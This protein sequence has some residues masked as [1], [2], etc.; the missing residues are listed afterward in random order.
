MTFFSKT[1]Y[2]HISSIL[3]PLSRDTHYY[4]VLSAFPFYTMLIH[5]RASVF[6]IASPTTYP[7][8]L[9]LDYFE[10]YRFEPTQV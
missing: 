4:V 10:G 2:L 3:Y 9:G 6:S 8:A 1:F 5:L 7:N